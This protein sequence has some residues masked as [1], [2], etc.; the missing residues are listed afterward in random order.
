VKQAESRTEDEPAASIMPSAK[1]IPAGLQL[2]DSAQLGTRIGSLAGPKVPN[3]T[4]WGPATS[5]FRRWILDRPTEV[6][7]TNRDDI[8]DMGDNWRFCLSQKLP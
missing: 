3:W 5:G 7:F 2:T 1:H 6:H 8:A 4:S